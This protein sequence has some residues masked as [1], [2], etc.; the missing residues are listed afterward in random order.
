MHLLCAL[1]TGCAKVHSLHIAG[2]SR[3][4]VTAGRGYR[5]ESFSRYSPPSTYD[6]PRSREERTQR[7]SPAPRFDR[8]RK[9]SPPRFDRDDSPP[10][11]KRGRGGGPPRGGGRG[12]PMSRG[13]RRRGGFAPR[14]SMS[15][16]F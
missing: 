13:P 12:P 11:V 4:S 16:R 9:M 8:V 10:P 3:G 7:M 1:V 2:R 15:H 5:S 6:V 14:R